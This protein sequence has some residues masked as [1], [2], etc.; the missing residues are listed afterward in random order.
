M[1]SCTRSSKIQTPSRTSP[2]ASPTVVY[3]TSTD[4]DVPCKNEFLFAFF[5]RS[6]FPLGTTHSIALALSACENPDDVGYKWKRGS[7]SAP[8][9]IYTYASL[10]TAVEARAVIQQW[11]YGGVELRILSSR[12]DERTI[13]RGGGRLRKARRPRYTCGRV[14]VESIVYDI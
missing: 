1:Y 11:T 7:A 4:V 8:A 5:F 3:T 9:R 10:V 2:T 12:R 6:H 14:R 13:R